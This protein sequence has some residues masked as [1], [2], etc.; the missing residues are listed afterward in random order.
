MKSEIT[1]ATRDEHCPLC[2]SETESV[3]QLQFNLKMQLPS[4][5]Y[6]RYCTEDN[7]LFLSSGCQSDYDAYY[8]SLANDTVHAEV[9]GTGPHSLISK[10]QSG[11]L[12]KALEGFFGRPKRIFDFGCG[13]G[14]LLVELASE[15]PSSKFSG[16]DPGPAAQIG[17]NKAG[18][19]GLD[20]LCITG[21]KTITEQ[22]PYDLVIA[23]HVIEHLLDFDLLS[24]LNALTSEGGLLYVE[25]PNSLEYE[26]RERREFLYYFDR[27]HVN[28]FTPQSLARLL[29][30]Y[31]FGYIK[32]FEFTFPYRDGGEYPALGMIF[33]KGRQATDLSSS[34]LIEMTKRYIAKEQQRAKTIAHQFD[35]HD[36]ILI[37]G[38]G[39]NFYR[40]MM[41]G[42]PLAGLCEIVVLDQRPQTLLIGNRTFTTENPVDGIR[43]YHAPVVITVSEGRKLLG[44][45]VRKIDP[46]RSVF[47]V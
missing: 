1:T 22:G 6:V 31:G 16:Y 46:K 23:S 44:E 14:S 43:R 30:S 20:N 13:E 15:F 37:W 45:Q 29:Y 25:V 19:L 26:N 38:A 9:S 5:V 36:Q 40:S 12:V 7:F 35:A 2:G 39:D 47:F 17:A 28:H 32:H 10:E 11:H 33:Q 18:I 3:L 8:K 34:S 27:L 21:L 4:N 41:N 24:E 42:G